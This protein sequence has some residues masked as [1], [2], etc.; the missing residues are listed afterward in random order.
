MILLVYVD[1]SADHFL[2]FPPSAAE[3]HEFDS[4]T[5]LFSCSFVS[6]TTEFTPAKQKRKYLF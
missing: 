1:Y 3:L 4:T 5:L 2:E 6:E